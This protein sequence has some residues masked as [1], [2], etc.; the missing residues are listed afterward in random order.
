MKRILSS[1][2]AYY[3]KPSRRKRLPTLA[4]C[5]RKI[6]K[7]MLREAF[8]DCDFEYRTLKEYMAY[9]KSIVKTEDDFINSLYNL[10]DAVSTNDEDRV[11]TTENLMRRIHEL[12]NM[13]IENASL[14]IE[15]VI[16]SIIARYE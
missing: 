3:K 8:D 4:E 2:A 5:T 16:N 12:S 1:S 9:L 14:Y 7:M 6:E 13:S 10:K 11:K 15:E